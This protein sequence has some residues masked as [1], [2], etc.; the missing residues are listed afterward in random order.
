M[1]KESVESDGRGSIIPYEPEQYGPGEE[2]GGGFLMPATAYSHPDSR[3][4]RGPA[5]PKAKRKGGD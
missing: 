4:D 3:S 1:T 5:A 2:G